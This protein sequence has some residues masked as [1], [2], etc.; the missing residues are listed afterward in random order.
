M[1]TWSCNIETSRT[2]APSAEATDVF[3][4]GERPPS[5]M[6]ISVTTS[7]DDLAP[8][9]CESCAISRLKPQGRNESPC[10]IRATS[11]KLDFGAA[12]GS[13][14]ERQRAGNR[15]ASAT[16]GPDHRRNSRWFGAVLRSMF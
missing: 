1:T 16:W 2:G 10:P 5:G 11:N 15:S 8:D 14:G 13:P 3:Q 4:H 9:A 7:C 12:T 6:P